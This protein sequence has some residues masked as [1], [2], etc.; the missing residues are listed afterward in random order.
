MTNIRKDLIEGELSNNYI[1]KFRTL[2]L[3]NRFMDNLFNKYY[4]HEL[5]INWYDSEPDIDENLFD[6]YFEYAYEDGHN[7]QAFIEVKRQIEDYRN[8]EDRLTHNTWQDP[9]CRGIWGMSQKQVDSMS[10]RILKYEIKRSEVSSR[11]RLY[12][13]KK[14][15]QIRI[16]WYGR[17]VVY[18]DYWFIFL[19]KRR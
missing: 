19:R 10:R 4:C 7:K 13:G 9:Y 8:S 11:D 18:C 5:C 15:N 3:S 14:D 12:I 6:E 1:D 17:D 16:Y 2:K